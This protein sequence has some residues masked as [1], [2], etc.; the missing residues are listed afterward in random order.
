[1]DVNAA[2]GKSFSNRV[3]SRER[4]NGACGAERNH[5]S[6]QKI[7]LGCPCCGMRRCKARAQQRVAGY[8]GK[9]GRRLHSCGGPG[10]PGAAG[11]HPHS[12][13]ICENDA[14]KDRKS[15]VL[16]KSESVCVDLGGCSSINTK[17]I[18]KI[19]HVHNSLNKQTQHKL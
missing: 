7:C 19:T 17:T 14:R 3:M 9:R 12:R 16:G 2:M 10:F 5:A 11:C 6:R 15:V 8:E 13:Q 18:S 1:M 4:H